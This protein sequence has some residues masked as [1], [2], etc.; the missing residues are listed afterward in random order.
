MHHTALANVALYWHFV[1]GVWLVV[2]TLL[3][4]V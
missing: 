2:L 4:Y 3:Y 1:D